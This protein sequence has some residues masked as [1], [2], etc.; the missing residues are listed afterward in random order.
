MNREVSIF[1]CEDH[2]SSEM[3]EKCNRRTETCATLAKYVADTQKIIDS[4]KDLTEEDTERLRRILNAEAAGKSLE[5]IDKEYFIWQPLC[6]RLD[7]STMNPAQ[8][9]I[10]PCD[11]YRPF[12]DV[13]ECWD[14]MLKHYPFGWLK[15]REEEGRNYHA[16]TS[17]DNDDNKVYVSDWK[18]GIDFDRMHF[19]FTFADGTFFGIKEEER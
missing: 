13:E 12:K 8:Y 6:E 14:E 2:C 19:E 16:I 1:F 5:V 7:F 10:R 17:L 3:M 9:R 15:D 4:R 11:N 18:G